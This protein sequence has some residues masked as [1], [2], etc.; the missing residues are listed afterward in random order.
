[1]NGS[2]HSPVSNRSV[3]FERANFDE[4]AEINDSGSLINEIHLEF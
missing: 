2:G 3:I 1:M 4:N